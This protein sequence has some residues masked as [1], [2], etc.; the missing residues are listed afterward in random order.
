MEL[1]FHMLEDAA[2]LA[3]EECIDGI[4]TIHGIYEWLGMHRIKDA[5]GRLLLLHHSNKSAKNTKM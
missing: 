5:T 2:S 4:W 3:H 1:N